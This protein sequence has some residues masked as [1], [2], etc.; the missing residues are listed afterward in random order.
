MT[1]ETQTQTHEHSHKHKQVP[2][3]LPHAPV[4]RVEEP[5]HEQLLALRKKLQH[6]KKESVFTLEDIESLA[7]QVGQVIADLREVRE[8][9]DGETTRNHV[10][11][12]L[13]DVWTGL[14][15]L[16]ASVANV[17]QM[18]YP[19]LVKFTAIKRQLDAMKQSGAFTEDD[20]LEVQEALTD[21][22]TRHVRDGKFFFNPAKYP[23]HGNPPSGQGLLN[24]L[25]NRCRREAHVLLVETEAIDSPTLKE[26]MNEL[27]K[28]ER[29]VRE[30]QKRGSYSLEQVRALQKKARDV[31]SKR[32]GGVFRDPDGSIPPGQARITAVLE[33]AFDDLHG[34]VIAKEEVS[35]PLRPIYERLVEL[36][37]Q[38]EKMLRNK[39]WTTTYADL[40]PLRQA[41]GEIDELRTPDGKITMDN[42]HGGQAEIPSGQA[43]VHQLLARCYHLVGMLARNSEAIAPDL[44]GLYTKLVDT[45]TDLLALAKKVRAKEQVS[46]EAVA[47]LQTTLA[48]VESHRKQDGTFH[49]QKLD[50]RSG[51]VP[52]GQAVL[53]ALLTECYD[54]L[55]EVRGAA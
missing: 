8:D 55:E 48:E 40:D 46:D 32:G 1:Q 28:I 41:L 13:D 12:I 9:E 22:E 5:V 7:T 10:D 20:I 27:V 23:D 11:D 26:S 30:I 4:P 45:R 49:T 21:I 51:R 53:T 6:L 52:R 42:G 15:T 37:I 25:L 2:A 17:D 47:L 3:D 18:L 35:G 50:E 29:E 36:K 31:D 33:R 43:V 39:R 14:F 24:I 38:L 19:L 34:L 54:L 16:W 44:E